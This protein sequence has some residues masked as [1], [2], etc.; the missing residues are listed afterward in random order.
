ML[1]S[2]RSSDSSLISC[3]SRTAVGGSWSGRPLAEARTKA[4]ARSKASVEMPS[5]RCDHRMCEIGTID[6][7]PTVENG[8][9]STC[10]PGNV[11]RTT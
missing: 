10:S 3:D 11:A 2:A 8:V 7:V 5:Q 4:R 6:S 9:G 1:T